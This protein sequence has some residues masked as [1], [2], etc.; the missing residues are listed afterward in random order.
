MGISGLAF[1]LKVLANGFDARD[2][3]VCTYA[4]IVGKGS[5]RE[6]NCWG[7]G[8]PTG[9]GLLGREVQAGANEG[10]ELLGVTGTAMFAAWQMLACNTESVGTEDDAFG[11]GRRRL[12]PPPLPFPS[13]AVTVAESEALDLAS[14]VLRSLAEVDDAAGL[15]TNDAMLA[16]CAMQWLGG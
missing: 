6:G 16:C 4:G 15:S 3:D 1:P 14:G 9:I 8:G 10:A 13:F 7:F 5:T 2:D 12:L 11:G